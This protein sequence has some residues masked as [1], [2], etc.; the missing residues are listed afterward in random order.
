MDRNEG[1]IKLTIPTI[2]LLECRK[3]KGGYH[4]DGIYDTDN[5]YPE[6][7]YAVDG[8]EIDPAICISGDDGYEP[9]TEESWYP[10]DYED[11]RDDDYENDRET[12]FGDSGLTPDSNG[13][14]VQ[15][16][17]IT[18]IGISEENI[19]HINYVVSLMP[20]IFSTLNVT[21]KTSMDIEGGGQFLPGEITLKDR[22]DGTIDV[23]AIKEEL[24]HQLQYNVLQS[25][26]QDMMST[27]RSNLEYQAKMLE[28]LIERLEDMPTSSFID[29]NVLG[30]FWDKCIIEEDFGLS[31][32][33]DYFIA[34]AADFFTEYMNMA[35]EEYKGDIDEN[36]NW[37]WDKYLEILG[38]KIKSES[39]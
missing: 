23:G 35:P 39:E 24:I 6:D 29:E 7:D 15:E 25:M 12:Y 18:Y 38:Y 33:Y 1:R 20:Q 22:G 4:E 21:V 36:F 3:F 30:D 11:Q 28:D 37:N 27:A 31:L 10:E 26:G 13:T 8:G 34:H 17:N 5:Y 16:N 9:E 2:D 19:G 14:G 32:N